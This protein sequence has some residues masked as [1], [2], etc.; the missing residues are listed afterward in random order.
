MILPDLLDRIPEAMGAFVAWHRS[1]TPLR[2]QVEIQVERSSDALLVG[3]R[4][5][6]TVCAYDADVCGGVLLVY[7]LEDLAYSHHAA[8]I[9][10]VLVSPALRGHGPKRLLLTSCAV[11]LLDAPSVVDRYGAATIGSGRLYL[12]SGVT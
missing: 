4:L 5:T 6:G 2:K 9:S 3:R 11:N 1:W 10:V 8:L 7:L 12:S